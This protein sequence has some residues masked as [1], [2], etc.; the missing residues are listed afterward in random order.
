M[1]SLIEKLPFCVVAA[2]GA[3]LFYLSV[4]IYIVFLPLIFLQSA[5]VCIFGWFVFTQRGKGLI[6]IHCGTDRSVEWLP[7]L[8]SLADQG[9]MFLDY[10][11]RRNWKFWSFPVRA[12]EAFGPRSIPEQF[13]TGL[14]PAIIVLKKFKWPRTF[15]FGSRCQE[16]E[17]KWEQLLAA[18]R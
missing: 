2:L 5:L 14:L 9:T 12:Y 6:I 10:D 4:A 1:R 17:L 13:T 16:L 3:T 8:R 11:D 7:R 18:L 15:A